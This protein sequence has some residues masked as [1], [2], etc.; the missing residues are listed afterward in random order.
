MMRGRESLAISVR[1]PDGQLEVTRE[2]LANIYK[3]RL[4][5]T[6]LVR[7]LIV[8]IEALVLGTRALFRSAQTA[9]AEEEG[10]IPAAALWG[11]VIASLALG[12]ALFFIAPLLAARSLDI[13]I[14]SDLLSNIVEGLI[15]I[16]IFIAY[17]KVI[18]LF[19]D[20][21]RVFAYHGAEHKV[22]NAYEAGR[23]L[24]VNEARAYSTAHARCGTSFIF[25]VL[26]ISILV[27]ALVGRPPLWLSILSRIIL[28]PVIA[29]LGYEAIKFGASHEKNMLI[30][31]FVAPGL[32]LQTMVTRE[33]DDGQL[34]AAISAL[35]EVIEA[36][37]PTVEPAVEEG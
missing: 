7:G 27:L 14:N 21:K 8:L 18:G 22:I 24:E 25:A 32:M 30:R 19:P 10:K 3:G 4:R 11:T 29:A 23:P 5:E 20:I 17:I 12:V 26:I 35:K 6:P 15:R 28:L 33:P 13:Y 16:G 34:E 36:D 37:S 1:R 9:A 31:L 2:P